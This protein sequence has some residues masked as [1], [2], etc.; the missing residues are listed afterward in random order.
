MRVFLSHSRENSSTASR[1]AQALKQNQIEVLMSP[2]TAPTDEGWRQATEQAI[3][4]AGAFLFL[5]GPGLESDR[6]E[7][8][9]WLTALQGDPGRSKT[10]I[11]VL[12]GDVQLPPF[13][14]DRIPLHLET[15]SPDYLGLIGRIKHLLQY[16]FE[17]VDP[18][19]YERGR[20]AQ[21]EGLEE[22]KR[23]AMAL[24]AAQGFLPRDRHVERP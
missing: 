15:T 23:F 19:S 16:P 21:K 7:Q 9:E 3:G 5:I 4:Q 17:V 12:V 2:Q 11:P 18:E 20:K 14:R 24:K 22:V 6:E 10:M 13:L 1:L 8:F